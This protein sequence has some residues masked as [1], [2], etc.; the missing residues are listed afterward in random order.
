MD[1]WPKRKSMATI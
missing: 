1:V